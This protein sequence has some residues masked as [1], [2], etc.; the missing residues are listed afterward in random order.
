MNKVENLDVAMVCVFM[1]NRLGFE[2]M[3][4]LEAP[5]NLPGQRLR[6]CKICGRSSELLK[7]SKRAP[8]HLAVRPC[9]FLETPAL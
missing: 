6:A 4:A 3:H 5:G 9:G 7:T 8:G 2:L 1:G